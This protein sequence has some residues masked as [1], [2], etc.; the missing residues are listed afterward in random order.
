MTP[1]MKSVH[2]MIQKRKERLRKRLNQLLN[3]EA[4]ELV[5]G[6]KHRHNIKGPRAGR[7]SG[8]FNSLF[9]KPKE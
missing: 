2:A 5:K 4:D 6:L 1:F 9:K 3:G 7:K 8:K